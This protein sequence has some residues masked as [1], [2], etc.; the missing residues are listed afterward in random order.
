M[1]FSGEGKFYHFILHI[2]PNVIS[3]FIIRTMGR[4]PNEDSDQLTHSSSLI[5][6][7]TVCFWVSQRCNVSSFGKGK[8]VSVHGH[9]DLS[10][11]WAHIHLSCP[12]LTHISLASLLWVI[13]TLQT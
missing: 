1:M 2:S 11:H 12:V 4:V 9:A 3:V 7:V 5:K 6:I 8:L 10:L 13:G